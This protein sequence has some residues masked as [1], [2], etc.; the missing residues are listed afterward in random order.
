MRFFPPVNTNNNKSNFD[1]A[2]RIRHIYGCV[3]NISPE[4]EKQKNDKK[5]TE[6]KMKK[7]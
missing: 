3:T 5:K 7:K 2:M 4:K 1:E 6:K